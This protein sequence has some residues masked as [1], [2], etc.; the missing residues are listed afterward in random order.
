MRYR[1]SRVTPRYSTGTWKLIKYEMTCARWTGITVDKAFS[2]M[3]ITSPTTK[4]RHERST[5]HD[6]ALT[7]SGQRRSRMYSGSSLT[8]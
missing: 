8:S 5:R 3:T 1:I 4:E 6:E 7:G 2:S